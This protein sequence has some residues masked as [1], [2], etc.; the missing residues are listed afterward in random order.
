[1]TALNET[2]IHDLL[3][4]NPGMWFTAK[5]I[6]DCLGIG[7]VLLVE[8]VITKLRHRRLIVLRDQDGVQIVQWRPWRSGRAA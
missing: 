4:S 1:M 5:A 6:S 8:R 3:V 7:H 2:A